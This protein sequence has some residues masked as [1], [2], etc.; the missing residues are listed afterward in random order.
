MT[1]M[2]TKL[3]QKLQIDHWKWERLSRVIELFLITAL[4]VTSMLNIR[5]LV[6][7][8]KLQLRPWVDIELK[9]ERNNVYFVH[10]NI[11]LS[12][13]KCVKMGTSLL[14]KPILPK[15]AQEIYDRLLKDSHVEYCL[16]PNEKM[17]SGKKTLEEIAGPKINLDD[18]DEFYIGHLVVYEDIYGRKHNY[19]ISGVIKR[20]DSNYSIIGV[21]EKIDVPLDYY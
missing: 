3:T 19:F 8:H 5:V 17:A 13:A 6:S 4:V 7:Q 2:E 20:V 21:T 16:L 12:P 10:K 1:K 9:T 11:G 14:K 15:A 18:Y